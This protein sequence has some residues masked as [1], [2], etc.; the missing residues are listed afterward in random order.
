VLFNSYIFVFVFLPITVTGFFLLGRVASRR[1]TLAWLVG[2]SLVYYG[3]W[4][5]NYLAL[6]G[7]S[8]LFNFS[9][10]RCLSS[11]MARDA[12]RRLLLVG[13]AV[14]L[15]LIGYFKYANFFVDTFDRLAGASYS[16]PPIVLP[17]AISFFTFQQ[18]AFLVDAYR[19]ETREH[20]FVDYCLF[21]TF[22]PQLIAG[23]IVHHKEMLPQ[24]TRRI[25]Y[26]LNSIDFS[27]GTTIFFIGLFKKV[28]LADHMATIANPVFDGALA[29]Q[30]PDLLNAWLGALAYS[31][32][33]YFDFSGYSDMAIG[34]GRLFGIKLPLNF[35]SPYKAVN[36]ID[37]WRRW[38]MT[39]SRFLKDYLYIPLGGNRLGKARR[40]ENLMVTMLLGGLWHGAGWTFVFWGGLHGAYLV[41]N[42]AW[43]A[44][45]R[46]GG[47]D[48]GESRWWG[49]ALG[50]FL[51]CFAAVIG[52]VFFRAE[53]FDAAQSILRA[54]TGLNG[55]HRPVTHVQVQEFCLML[56]CMA[57]VWFLP[58]AQD[59][60]VRF[61]P[62]LQYGRSL[63]RRRANVA[64]LFRV[65]WRP[66][67]QWAVFVA[68]ISVVSV[69]QMSKVTEF[70]YYQF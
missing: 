38:H 20:R 46:A 60:F 17:L 69:L 22:F 9:V 11:G 15:G 7:F 6:L 51:T 19:G 34:L 36:M 2:C 70:I 31:F 39:L 1:V 58:N 61:K 23:P 28:V 50:C 53:T 8:V 41:I 14:N 4:N 45:R 16:L 66:T 48:L 37:F 21:V 57:F 59:L 44:I 52:W 3:W 18:I 49:R 40:Y 10:G 13:I 33:I 12:R 68:I 47:R 55:L 32:Q 30:H 67:P 56:A 63:D 43:H 27:I 29:D 25:R 62:A 64:G 54:M 5:A 65:L 26:R 42:H 35:N 24:F